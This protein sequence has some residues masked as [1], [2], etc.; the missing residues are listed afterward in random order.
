M[1]VIVFCFDLGSS[2]STPLVIQK[3]SCEVLGSRSATSQGVMFESRVL[4]ILIED[5]FLGMRINIS[6][7]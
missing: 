7:H 2:N 1:I 4:D 5:E 6:I 3:G